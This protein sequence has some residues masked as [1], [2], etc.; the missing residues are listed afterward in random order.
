MDKGGEDLH[1]AVLL[2]GELLKE[3]LLPEGGP[4]TVD[5]GGE[6]LHGA[7]LLH[8]ELLPVVLLP[9]ESQNSV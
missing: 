7:I 5:K 1:C 8:G 4:G 6:D 3:I 2:H 9:K